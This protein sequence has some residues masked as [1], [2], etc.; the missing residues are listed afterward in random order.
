[1]NNLQYTYPGNKISEKCPSGVE[2]FNQHLYPIL[3]TRISF[4]RLFVL[5]RNAQGTPPD[6]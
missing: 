1:M 2:M 5:L 4:V 3:D 6:F